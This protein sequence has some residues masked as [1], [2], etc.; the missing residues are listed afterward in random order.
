[1]Y[2]GKLTLY[3]C[4]DLIDDY[5]GIAGYEEYRDDLRLLYLV[6]VDPDTGKLAGLRMVPLQARQLRVRHA[7]SD[8]A[9]WL[10]GVLDRV[11]RGFGSRVNLDP[12]G[13]LTLRPT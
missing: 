12:D 2:R 4:G 8:D 6:S 13:T 11:S 9:A 5:E 3:G 7:S 10:R 1:V